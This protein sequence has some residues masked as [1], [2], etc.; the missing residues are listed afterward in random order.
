MEPKKGEITDGE[1][2]LLDI[3]RE[4]GIKWL[5]VGVSLG[6]EVNILTS[7]VGSKP[8]EDHMK[9]FHM[10]LEWRN[11]VPDGFTYGN[12]A[13][14]LEAAGLVKCARDHCYADN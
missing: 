12:L 5:E 7:V 2:F 10:L 4:I 1:R 9:A 14:A 3:A 6:I 11:R 8:V 13:S